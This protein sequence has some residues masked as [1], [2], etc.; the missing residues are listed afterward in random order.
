[1]KKRCCLLLTIVFIMSL[2]LSG[3][4][5]A[6]EANG[7][8]STGQTTSDAVYNEDAAVET[9]QPAD[10]AVVE[11]EQPVSE[12]ETALPAEDLVPEEVGTE[13]P[14]EPL[15]GSW[16]DVTQLAEQVDRE[17]ADARPVVKL[18]A[19]IMAFKG[20]RGWDA[21]HL[22]AVSRKINLATRYHLSYINTHP[23]AKRAI[24]LM[25]DETVRLARKYVQRDKVQAIVY[26]N[27][28]QTYAMLG[29]YKRAAA[30]AERAL[31]YS[32]NRAGDYANLKKL[33]NKAGE[34]GLKVFVKGQRPNFDVKPK[35]T[36]G[37]TMVPL[38]AI[39]ETMGAKVNYDSKLQRVN[40]VNGNINVNLYL[41]NKN[42]VV[43]GKKVLLDEPAGS[44]NGRTMVPLRFVSENLGANVVYDNQT[45]TITVE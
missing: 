42:A 5:F 9:E 26:K 6:E 28:A 43:N 21:P 32:D 11:T 33:Y 20:T 35:V 16:E 7:V 38:R 25:T 40:I 45:E 18:Q 4:A 22:V 39:S 30:V 31:K 36:N 8:T 1:M 10:N 19:L 14:P 44:V 37:R 41:N 34:K 27:A 23:K 29:M 12:L 17:L 15:A 2:M 24:V 13:A 3:V